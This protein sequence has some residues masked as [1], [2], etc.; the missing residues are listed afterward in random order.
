LAKDVAET[1]RKLKEVVVPLF[2]RRRCW[3]YANGRSVGFTN[4]PSHGTA[5]FLKL[6]NV[7]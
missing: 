2:N 5:G 3:Y 4:N 6:S 1:I 7:I